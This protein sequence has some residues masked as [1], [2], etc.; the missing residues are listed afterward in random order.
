M[1]SMI[2]ETNE[3]RHRVSGDAKQ[4]AATME[5]VA[6]VITTPGAPRRLSS[7]INSRQPSAAPRRSEA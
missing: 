7:G 1:A 6:A 4:R 3:T 5:S 2:R